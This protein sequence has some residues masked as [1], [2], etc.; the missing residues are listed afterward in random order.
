VGGEAERV[1]QNVHGESPSERAGQ[2]VS[3]DIEDSYGLGGG[4][5]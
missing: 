3:F 1:L 2:P 4:S 5:T